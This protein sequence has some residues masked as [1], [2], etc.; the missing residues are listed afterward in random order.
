MSENDKKRNLRLLFFVI[1]FKRVWKVTLLWKFCQK[2][3][4]TNV[5]KNFRKLFLTFSGFARILLIQFGVLITCSRRTETICVPKLMKFQVAI[6]VPNN[7]SIDRATKMHLKH[8]VAVQYDAIGKIELF[9][10]T[11]YV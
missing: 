10:C 7:E 1:I 5:A 4:E 11:G 8:K 9:L 3:R 6:L 2:N